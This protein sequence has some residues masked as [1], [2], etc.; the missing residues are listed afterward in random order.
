LIQFQ[1]PEVILKR[2]SISR[3]QRRYVDLLLE[4]PSSDVLVA[5]Q[6]VSQRS[7]GSYTVL[8]RILKPFPDPQITDLEKY[9]HLE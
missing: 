8:W 4:T 6:P 9:V 2:Q 7:D 3:A 5:F 1:L